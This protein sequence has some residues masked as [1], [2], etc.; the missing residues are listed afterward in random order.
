MA[1]VL[2]ARLDE[3]ASAAE[4]TGAP[5]DA[6]ARLLASAAVAT[7]RA[8][9]LDLLSESAARQIWRDAETRPDLRH[10]LHRLALQERHQG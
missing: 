10:A 6:V 4:R 5:P 1:R 9:A 7:T 8:V 2:A 3:V